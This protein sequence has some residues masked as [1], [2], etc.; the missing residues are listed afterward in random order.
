MSSMYSLSPT[1]TT[2]HFHEVLQHWT[3]AAY[4]DCHKFDGVGTTHYIVKSKIDFLCLQL[5]GV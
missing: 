1:I 5:A 2:I 3:E 4:M